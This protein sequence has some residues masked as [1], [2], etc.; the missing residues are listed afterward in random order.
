MRRVAQLTLLCVL[1]AVAALP[2]Q[3]QS[4]D[5]GSPLYEANMCGA[6]LP[7]ETQFTIAATGDTF[8]HENIQ[9]IGEAQGYDTLFDQVR[10][11]LNAADVAYT[12][13]DGAMLEGASYSG[14]PNFNYNPKLAAALKNAG[15]GLVSTANNHIMD[16]GP[17]GLDATMRVLEQNGI[18]YHGTVPSSWGEKPRPPY[19]KIPLSR[20]GIT[21][22]LGF[23]SATWGTNGIADPYNQVNLLYG[24]NAYGEQGGVRQSVLDAIAQAR[25]ETDLVIVAVHWGFEYQFAPDQTQ[26]DAAQKLAAAGA[27]LILGA[28]PH[29]LQPVD[30]IDT[31]GRKTLVA[32]SLANFLASQGAFQAQY[33]SATSTVFYV[34]LLRS[35]DGKLRVSGYRY[36]PTIH[37]DN[38]TR[39]APIPPQGYEDVIS[40]VRTMMRDPSGLHQIS[41]DQAVLPKRVEICPSYG[42]AE[43]PGKA[44]GGDFATL[45]ATLGGDAPVS[46]A[47]AL[48]VLGLPL[49]PPRQELSGDCKRET[50]VLYTPL[51]RLEWH[52]EQPW[53]YRVVGT[54]LGAAVY[55][56][57][58]R[59]EPAREDA[60]AITNAAFRR[61]YETY[62]GLAIFGLPISND[63]QEGAITVQYF[64]R[65][66]FEAVPEANS[67]AP[68]I[69][70]VR[71]GKLNEAYVGIAAVCGLAAT[72][73]PAAND[74]QPKPL[75][76]ANRS[77]QLANQDAPS[78]PFGFMWFGLLVALAAGLIG[79]WIA[80]Q[81]STM[82]RAAARVRARQQ[83][84]AAPIA[85][86]D[87]DVLR[88]LL[89]V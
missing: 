84:T 72:A 12:N 21:A 44:V 75:V 29:T 34:G 25:R 86:S 35:P 5:L 46:Q 43:A 53:P 30:I 14:Y 68:L 83:R 26:V 61:F 67:N 17:E 40:H 50:R 69:Q 58:Y 59:A 38:D 88:D 33:Y 77:N 71:L 89:D 82:P 11:F 62:G 20:D 31:G 39:P 54:Q 10:P 55:R 64:E 41:A 48:A 9:A 18:R 22:T 3:A 81:Q 42:F 70:Q 19:I 45:Y 65:A 2:A 63:M 79:G 4:G 32:Y 52:P 23:V 28:Q 24:S 16:R 47:A 73:G 6:G 15:I 87:D 57:K 80:F 76:I 78:F 85:Q 49:G 7:G 1:F 27:D 66:R 37:V 13:F 74:G 60:S 36:L 51:Q 8:P 56:Q